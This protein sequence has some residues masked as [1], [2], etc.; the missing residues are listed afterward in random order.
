[1][2]WRLI[3]GVSLL[4][5][6]GLALWWY[7]ASSPAA[8]APTA[9]PP[10]QSESISATNTRTAVIVR[11]QFFSWQELESSNYATYLKN[12]RA[13][14]CP[15]ETIRDILLADVNQMLREKYLSG[16][17]GPKANPRWWTNFRTNDGR[18]DERTSVA[19]F[20]EERNVIMTQL[21]GP[22]WQKDYGRDSS[23]THSPSNQVLATLEADNSLRNL[24]ADQK[25]LVVQVLS[26][27]ADSEFESP[28]AVQAA[29]QSHWAAL[30]SALSPEQLELVKLHFSSWAEQL[31]EKLDGLIEFDTQPEEFRS[32]YRN[33]VDL[34]ARLAALAGQSDDA[35]ND[36][37]AALDA[38]LETA[39]RNSLAP[40]RYAL[41][42]RLNDPAYVSAMDEAK[43]SERNVT[44]DT[45]A[46]IYAIKRERNAEQARIENDPTLTSAQREI[47]LKQLELD[48]LKAITLA[49][50][51]A[52][53]P[54][55]DAPSPP[56]PE[57]MKTHNVRPGEGLN[58]IA[59]VYGV[60]PEVLRAAN[61]QLDFNHLPA[62]AKVNVPLRYLYPLPP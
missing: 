17:A 41:Y 9:V 56:R 14:G 29:E 15:E 34:Q 61:P 2:F 51:E 13:I 37:R 39:I 23:A 19:N 42:V 54:E 36:E 28:A 22:D 62:G 44:P 59:S 40:A 50:G 53:P 16:L 6:L 49:Q 60:A 7:H 31:R 20:I 26:A 52:L 27:T 8:A 25:Q 32:I 1:M 12:L 35:A 3:L 38:E 33:T 5:N 30:S 43:T 10:A 11:P 24:T 57:P 48:Q 4:A 55:P 18:H 58:Q 21:F 45:L 47:E 46:L